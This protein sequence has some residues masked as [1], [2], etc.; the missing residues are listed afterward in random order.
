MEME[1][2]TKIRRPYY[3]VPENLVKKAESI[4]YTELRIEEL[5]KQLKNESSIRK[6]LSMQESLR[7]NK[8]IKQALVES[9]WRDV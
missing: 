7:A 9:Y 2:Q 6:K 3:E 5:T 1:R 4:K 8:A